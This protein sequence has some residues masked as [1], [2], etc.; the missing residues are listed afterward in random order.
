MKGQAIIVRMPQSGWFTCT[1][2]WPR[3]LAKDFMQE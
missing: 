2:R 3:T 1:P